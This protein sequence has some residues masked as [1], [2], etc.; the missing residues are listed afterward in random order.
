M[1]GLE[2]DQT[3]LHL[4]HDLQATRTDKKEAR[5]PTHDNLLE[6]RL[7]GTTTCRNHELSEPTERD[8][9]PAATDQ[10]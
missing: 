4:H 3:K 1:I 8:P 2:H 7:V 9:R 10:K 5:N 6:P